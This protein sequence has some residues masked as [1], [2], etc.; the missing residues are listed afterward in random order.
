MIIL[1][2]GLQA[3]WRGPEEDCWVEAFGTLRRH[4]RYSSRSARLFRRDDDDGRVW[5]NVY[6]TRVQT[7]P[8]PFR[9]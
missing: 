8:T 1:D 3:L 5:V 7:P 9:P 6:A 2:R 4:S